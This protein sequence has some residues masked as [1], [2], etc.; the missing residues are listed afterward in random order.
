[1]FAASAP[2]PLSEEDRQRWAESQRQVAADRAAFQ[3]TLHDLRKR[4]ARENATR[5]AAKTAQEA[6]KRQHIAAMKTA[7]ET[8]R[9]AQQEQ[10]QQQLADLGA[11]EQAIK[12]RT[13]SRLFASCLANTASAFTT[14]RILS[15]VW[16]H[17][18]CAASEN[19]GIAS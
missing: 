6:V 12:A 5:E 15:K 18:H 10:R 7:R 11:R 8:K 2:P 19:R 9:A 1:M 13:L 16:G 17:L 14:A 3:Q 4:W